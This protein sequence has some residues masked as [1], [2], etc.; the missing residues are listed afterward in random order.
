MRQLAIV[1]RYETF[2]HYTYPIFMGIPRAH[3]IVRDRAISA[4][5]D[6]PRL[7]IEAGKSSQVSKLYIADAG[8]AHLRSILRFCAHPCRKLI[9]RHQHET[10]SVHLAETGRML[11]AWI[12][13][14][15]GR[16]KGG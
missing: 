9:S 3:Y 14:Q 4:A 8:L 2:L 11:G 7:F 1:E 5:L 13:T 12:R 10:A 15:Q 16:A 6:Q